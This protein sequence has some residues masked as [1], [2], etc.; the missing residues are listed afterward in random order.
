MMQSL[1]ILVVLI[2]LSITVLIF[3]VLGYAINYFFPDLGNWWFLV[4]PVTL[5]VSFGLT[6]LSVKFLS[7]SYAQYQRKKIEKIS[8]KHANRDY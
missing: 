7:Q 2:L 4:A 8:K 5:V 1:A 6:N 3:A